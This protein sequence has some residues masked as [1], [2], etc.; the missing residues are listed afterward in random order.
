MTLSRILII[1]V[2]ATMTATCISC[3]TDDIRQS[4]NPLIDNPQHEQPGPEPPSEELS[5]RNE[6][7]RPQVHFTPERNWINDPNGMVYIDGTYHL[8]YQYNPQGNV[9]GNLSWGHAT[10]SDLLHWKEQSVALQPDALGMIFSGSAVCDKENTAG[11]GKNALVAVY[12]SADAAQ[13]QSVAYSTDN[14]KSFT[15]YEGNPVIKNNDDN[16]RDPKVFWHEDSKRWIMTLAKGWKKGIEI[17]SS[18]NLKSWTKE[19]EFFKPLAGRPDF[20]WECPDLLS[21]NFNGQR[22]W[23]LIV[24]V[25]PCG[26]VVGSGTMYFVG[27]FDGK[28]FTADALDYP[29]WLDYGMDNY[30]GVT[31][32]NTGDRKL[33]IGWMNNWQYADRVPCD[34]WRSAMTLPRELALVD[35]NGSP[36]LTCPVVKE[37]DGIA[38]DWVPVESSF[39]TKD[40]YHLQL[41]LNLDQNTTVTL[42]NS[43]GENFSIDVYA[44]SRM[45]SV[46]RNSKTGASSFSSMFSIASINAPLNTDGETVTLD[47]Y[48]DRSSVE[49]FSGN[50][51]TSITNLVFPQSLYNSLTVSGAKYEA[52]K[53]EL[54][55]VWQ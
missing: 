50:G 54:N 11:F 1:H 24:S 35:Y 8:F 14:G 49:L 10:S 16:L 20:Q 34:P 39:D 40:A 53:R 45:L 52:R 13:Q 21:F 51:R 29:L 26:P 44:S 42:S 37:I 2:V 18:S 33:F 17:W 25:N 46:H 7:Y 36:L 4:D 27:D 30:A 47:F 19:S 5:S 31:W 43:Q 6:T 55:R 22:K 12:T 41:V 38:G 32:S 23:V 15:K 9:W 48:V 28:N 3:S